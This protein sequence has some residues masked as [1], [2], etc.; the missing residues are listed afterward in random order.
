MLFRPALVLTA[1]LSLAPATKA[2]ISAHAF[3]SNCLLGGDNLAVQVWDDGRQVC[4]LGQGKY[5]ASDETTFDWDENSGCEPGYRVHATS[6]GR[7]VSV[8]APNGYSANL[9]VTANQQS[10]PKCG[11][12]VA[13]IANEVPIR[14]L[15]IETCLSDGNACDND[16]CRLCDYMTYCD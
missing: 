8:T 16:P 1:A 15:Q 13:G 6:N 11:T 3:M 14:G 4:F 5:F 12:A 10:N 2:C 9:R 7:E